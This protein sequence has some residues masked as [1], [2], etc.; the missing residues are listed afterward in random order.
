MLE[1]A[2]QQ[3]KGKGRRLAGAGLGCAHDVM[4]LQHHRNGLGLNRGHGGV[5]HVRHGAGQG[6][7]QLQLGKGHRCVGSFGRG[8]GQFEGEIRSQIGHS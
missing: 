6:R 3:R 5:T 8:R 7:C 4:A 1:H 2:L